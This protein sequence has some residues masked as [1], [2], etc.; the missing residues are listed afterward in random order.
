[1]RYTTISNDVLFRRRVTPCNVLLG[2][3][4]DAQEIEKIEEYC[5]GDL[6]EA[7]VANEGSELDK[8]I[9]ESKIRFVKKD[10]QNSWVFNKFN[11]L[12]YNI[13][14]E[15]Y[16]FELY[17]YDVLQYTVYDG[18][19]NG[20]YDWHSDLLYGLDLGETL[21]SSI[22]RKMT[23]VM[24]LNE[25]GKDFTGGEFQINVGR[26][27][28]AKTFDIEKGSVILFPSFVLHRVKPVLSGVRKSLVI[29]VEGPK[30]R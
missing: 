11:Q 14:E 16:G 9:R 17:G 8:N 29:W 5:S 13:N 19:D 30:F 21:H 24:L 1:M 28:E 23:M 12:A 20:H 25:S 22:T 6:S 3:V 27:S 7:K 2:N 18:D 4:F 10:M 26:E 15:F